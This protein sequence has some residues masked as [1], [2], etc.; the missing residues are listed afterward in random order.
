MIAGFVSLSIGITAVVLYMIEPGT[1]KLV[2]RLA[3]ESKVNCR[4]P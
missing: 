2:V 4:E 3:A 1:E